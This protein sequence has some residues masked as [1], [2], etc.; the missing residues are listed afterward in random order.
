LA[1]VLG[2]NWEF[3]LCHVHDVTEV[4]LIRAH[5]RRSKLMSSSSSRRCCLEFEGEKITIPSD[6]YAGTN[7]LTNYRQPYQVA[8]IIALPV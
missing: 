7:Y 8:V 1:D 5:A 2:T 3:L 6:E 4:N